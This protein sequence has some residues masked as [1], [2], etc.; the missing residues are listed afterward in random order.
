VAAPVPGRRR[1]LA[2]VAVVA[3]VVAAAVAIG[4]RRGSG[5]S[6]EI[7]GRRSS[8]KAPYRAPGAP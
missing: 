2:I 8:E 1:W 5:S 6:G 4:F 7:R 3:L